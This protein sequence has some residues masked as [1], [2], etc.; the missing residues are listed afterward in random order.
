MAIKKIANQVKL[1]STKLYAAFAI[2]IL[3]ATSF[4]LRLT[5]LISNLPLNLVTAL[6][7]KNGV[8]LIF[9]S[10]LLIALHIVELMRFK[11]ML[12]KEDQGN[13][14]SRR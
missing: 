6:I 12:E 8:G 3:V 14:V 2:L 10:M 9:I 13:V 7:V 11:E 1:K 4:L 5:P